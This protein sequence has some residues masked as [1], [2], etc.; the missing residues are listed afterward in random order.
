MWLVPGKSSVVFLE[1]NSS[2]GCHIG[3][4]EL[5][6]RASPLVSLTAVGLFQREEAT[7]TQENNF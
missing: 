3:H 7:G 1:K 5:G 6:P 2:L 4:E